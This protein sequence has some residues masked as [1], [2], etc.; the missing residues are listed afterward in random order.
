MNSEPRQKKNR[1]YLW[2]LPGILI[3]ALIWYFFPPSSQLRPPELKQATLLPEARLLQPFE[4]LDTSGRPFTNQQ[5][6]GHWS[7]VFFGYTHCPDVCPT[8]LQTLATSIKRLSAANPQQELPQ[9]VF[10]SVDPERD[11]MDRLKQFTGYFNDAFVGVSGK[12]EQI[13]SLTSQLGIIY[14]RVKQGPGS[15]YLVDHSAAILLIDPNGHFRAVF[16]VP[17]DPDKISRDF[18]SIKKYFEARYR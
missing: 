8:T 4:L 17:H 5:L 14:A 13:K 12:P 9:V 10:V 6:E 16:N 7:F 15:N 2:V 3:A 1:E 11:S 18:Q